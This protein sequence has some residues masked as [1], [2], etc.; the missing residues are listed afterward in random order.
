M[1]AETALYWIIRAASFPFQWMPYSWIQAIGRVLGNLIY[2]CIPNY[3]KRTLSNLAF[4][5][6]L[7]LSQKELIRVSKESFQNLAIICLEYPRLSREKRLS[8][9]ILC[10]N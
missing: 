5:K 8:P 9:K 10:E 1:P 6:D 7:G 3:R 4:A 2:Y